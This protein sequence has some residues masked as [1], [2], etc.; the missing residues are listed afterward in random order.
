MQSSVRTRYR[1]ECAPQLL[2]LHRAALDV[3]LDPSRRADDDVHAAAQRL[4]L[5]RVRGAAVDAHR[6]Q[7]ARG[8]DV[9]EIFVHL[10]VDITALGAS[11]VGTDNPQAACCADVLE[12]LMHQHVP[13]AWLSCCK[14]DER[15]ATV[16]LIATRASAPAGRRRGAAIAH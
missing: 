12:T 3:V 16:R 9:L 7:V 14:R 4:L 6:A 8:A 5:R 15:G 11:K 10:N 13:L 1:A 2:H